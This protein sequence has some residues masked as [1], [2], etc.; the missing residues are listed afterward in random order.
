MEIDVTS[1]VSFEAS[2]SS[3]WLL[4][5]GKVTCWMKFSESRVTCN[6]NAIAVD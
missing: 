6:L 1:D 2:M 5:V 3:I 4:R